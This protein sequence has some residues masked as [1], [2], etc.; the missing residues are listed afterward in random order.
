[1]KRKGLRVYAPR[2]GRFLDTDESID[3]FGLLI[4][5]LGRPPAAEFHGR[6]YDN[7]QDWVE[8]G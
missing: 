3:V 8:T 7:Y 5:I 2:A 6:D 1:L 4:R